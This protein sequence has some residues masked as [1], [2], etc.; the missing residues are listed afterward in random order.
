MYRWNVGMDAWEHGL[1]G[2]PLALHYGFA[3]FGTPG[4]DPG[5]W[6][7]DAFDGIAE[8]VTAGGNAMYLHTLEGQALLSIPGGLLG[9]GP[10]TIGDFDNDGRPRS[11]PPAAPRTR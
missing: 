11:P 2:A 6:N 3:D 9:G 1:P 10:P 5:E 8:I 7:A 4:V